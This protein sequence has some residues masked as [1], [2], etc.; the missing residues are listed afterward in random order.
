V[1]ERRDLLGDPRT[2]PQRHDQHAKGEADAFGRRG[3]TGEHERAVQDRVTCTGNE[4]INHPRR[5]EAERLGM[6]GRGDGVGNGCVAVAETRQEHA[7]R[8]NG[9]EVPLQWAR[10]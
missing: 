8:G 7:D 10:G 9:Q 4:L 6:H 3:R 1:L 5:L 2:F